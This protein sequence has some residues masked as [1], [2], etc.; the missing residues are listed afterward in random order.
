V[1]RGAQGRAR[2]PYYWLRFGREA[3]EVRT[4]TDMAALRDGHV[5]VTPLHLDLTAN[6]VM[7]PIRK[8]LA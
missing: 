4:G 2:L 7:D 3:P 1:D 5:S 6:E 8:A